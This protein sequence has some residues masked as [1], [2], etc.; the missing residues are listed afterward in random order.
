[1][2]TSS[3]TETWKHATLRRIIEI[4]F[5]QKSLPLR[6]NLFKRV[7]DLLSRFR[8]SSQTYFREKWRRMIFRPQQGETLRQILSLRNYVVAK[9]RFYEV[10]SADRFVH[11]DVL[12]VRPDH[13]NNGVGTAL[14]RSCIARAS[15][16]AAACV[17]QFT[18]GAAQ[19]IGTFHPS[20]FVLQTIL[21][22]L[23]YRNWPKL[24]SYARRRIRG[25]NW[26]RKKEWERESQLFHQWK[27]SRFE[28]LVGQ[29]RVYSQVLSLLSSQQV[30][31]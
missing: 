8:H 12:C 10:R 13:Q 14:L 1:M 3:S 15:Y 21:E 26:H 19:T 5:K 25:K 6:L 22:E 28:E 18:S 16:V 27:E 31:F 29:L 7:A 24:V 20:F 2:A 4:N 11:V 17:G 9:A 23:Q 30:G